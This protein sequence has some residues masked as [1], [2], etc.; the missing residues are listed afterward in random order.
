[1]KDS[2]VHH[3]LKRVNKIALKTIPHQ[4]ERENH[5]KGSQVPTPRI[6]NLVLAPSSYMPTMN[7][8]VPHHKTML[9]IFVICSKVLELDV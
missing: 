7:L 1:M 5:N 2:N 9:I 8:R 3:F 4:L 6:E